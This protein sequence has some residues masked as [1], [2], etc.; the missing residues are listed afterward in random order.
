MVAPPRLSQ[1]LGNKEEESVPPYYGVAHHYMYILQDSGQFGATWC[2]ADL[3]IWCRTLV[4]GMV[5]RAGGAG[6]GDEKG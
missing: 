4:L 2:C 6:S 3:N 5:T 1:A